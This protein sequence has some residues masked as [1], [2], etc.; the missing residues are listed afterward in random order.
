MNNDKNL[1]HF[2]QK[3][4]TLGHVFADFREQFKAPPISFVS[5][6]TQTANFVEIKHISL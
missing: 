1:L 5:S 3:L 2:L 4:F 6:N